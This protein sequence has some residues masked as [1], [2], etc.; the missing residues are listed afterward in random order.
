MSGSNEHNSVEDISSDSQSP[1]SKSIRAEF[2]ENMEDVFRWGRFADLTV[3]TT[4]E[5]ATPE[6]SFVVHKCILEGK[7]LTS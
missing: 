1:I 2:V 4:D 6:N 5:T 7:C 3:K